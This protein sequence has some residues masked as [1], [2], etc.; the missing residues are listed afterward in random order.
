MAGRPVR[1]QSFC[2]NP[3]PPA[4]FAS[5]C[6]ERPACDQPTLNVGSRI[7]SSRGSFRRTVRW[8]GCR[9]DCERTLRHR[10]GD[11]GRRSRNPGD[12]PRACRVRAAVAFVRRNRRAAR[13][14]AVRRRHAAPKYCSDGKTANPVCFALYFHNFSTFLAKPGLYLE[15][16]FVRPESAPPRATVA[17][18]WSGSRR[19]RSNVAVGGS[20]GRSSTGTARR[21]GSTSRSARR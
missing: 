4:P 7:R 20:S 9:R 17:R 11:A 5:T 19:S 13:T 21:S 18:C 6:A 10:A 14:P 3:A 2:H 1:G 16:L 12:D 15:D 8:L